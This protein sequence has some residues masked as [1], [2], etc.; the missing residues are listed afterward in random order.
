MAS[1][2]YNRFALDAGGNRISRKLTWQQDRWGESGF[3]RPVSRQ[4]AGGHSKVAPSVRRAVR[5]GNVNFIEIVASASF[6]DRVAH[7]Q[8][9]AG[10]GEIRVSWPLDCKERE[11]ESNF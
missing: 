2:S 3:E 7:L 5:D 11:R 6:P 8:L 9:A 4:V 10:D 1:S